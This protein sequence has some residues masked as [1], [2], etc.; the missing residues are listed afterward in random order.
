LNVHGVNDARQTEIHTAELLVTGPSDFEFEWVIEKL[1][2]TNH[3]VLIKYQQNLSRQVV[4]NFAMRFMNI[5]LLFR[6]RI[7]CLRSG[8]AI[9]DCSNYRSV[10]L[11][12]TTY[13]ILS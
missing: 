1:K 5:L 3:Q 4:E 11:L 13:E 2:F 12:P 10:S 9:N 6:M 7:N 8:R